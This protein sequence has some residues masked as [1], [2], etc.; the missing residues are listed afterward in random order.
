[1][2]STGRRHMRRFPRICQTGESGGVGQGCM[3]VRDAGWMGMFRL[4]ACL[5]KKER[6]EE[7]PVFRLGEV[8]EYVGIVGMSKSSSVRNDGGRDFRDY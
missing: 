2:R 4:F 6:V 8:G 3:D 5:M 1:M 7:G